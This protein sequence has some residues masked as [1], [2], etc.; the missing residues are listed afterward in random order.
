MP[1]PTAVTEPAP[2]PSA[3]QNNL[4]YVLAGESSG[5]LHASNLVRAL[6]AH[7]PELQFRG[8]GGDKLAA[9][10]MTLVKHIRETNFMGFVEVVKNLRSI[11]RMFRQVKADI[12]AQQPATILL[13]DYPGFNLRMAK[14]AKTALQPAPTVVYYISPQVWAWKTSRVKTIRAYTDLMLCILPFEEA[15]FQEHQVPVTFVGHPLLDAIAP[16]LEVPPGRLRQEMQLPGEKKLVA[17]LPGSR[18]AEIKRM[19]GPMLEVARRLPQVAFVLAGAGTQT[20]DF[21]REQLA[22]TH[23]HLV[24]DRTYDV[25]QAADYALVTSGT[26]TLETALFGV[27]QIVCYRGDWLSYQIA[28][29]LVMG[30][31][32]YISLVNL[33]LDKPAVPELIQGAMNPNRLEQE[34]RKLLAEGAVTQQM[35]A[36]YHTLWQR[37]GAT[38]ASH[39]AAEAILPLL[40]T[41][42]P[43]EKL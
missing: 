42:L 6:K 13:I 3:S 29:R 7:R 2:T 24:H 43:A 10:G 9:E 38:G 20:E 4:V 1:T 34:L 14:W 8:M 35:R 19:L 39:V 5:D 11:K 23:V 12:A 21:F 40:P 37:L 30:R 16:Q 36:D 41:A 25:L 33:I 15:F 18:K 28:K 32:E 27:P 17:L 31:I 26:A 22:D